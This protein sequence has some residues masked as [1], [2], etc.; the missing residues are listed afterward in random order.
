M[1]YTS[2]RRGIQVRTLA[3]DP[4]VRADPAAEEAFQPL[5]NLNFVQDA[6]CVRSKASLE[7]N[8]RSDQ[9]NDS[10]KPDQVT[11]LILLIRALRADLGWQAAEKGPSAATCTWTFLSS[12]PV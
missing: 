5:K 3:P 11:S 7:A 8:L 6:R 9:N 2:L 1:A 10:D 4:R 12:L